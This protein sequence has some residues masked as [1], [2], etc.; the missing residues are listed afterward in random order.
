[1]FSPADDS[2][3]D[4]YLKHKQVKSLVDQQKN[5]LKINLPQEIVSWF[6]E[7]PTDEEWESMHLS[8]GRT[9]ASCLGNDIDYLKIADWVSDPKELLKEIAGLESQLPV[10]VR[11]GSYGNQK[12]KQLAHFM[13]TGETGTNL[14]KNP[15][16]I[17][18]INGIPLSKDQL[19]VFDKLIT[20]YAIEELPAK[21]KKILLKQFNT[22]KDAMIKLLNNMN[23]H[24]QIEYQS[25]QDLLTSKNKPQTVE[26]YQRTRM[27]LNYYKGYI[28][29]VRTDG[30]QLIVGDKKDMKMMQENGFMPIDTYG[31]SFDPH[32]QKVYY[33][34]DYNQHATFNEGLVRIVH[35]TY[36]GISQ[37]VATSLE[38]V[39]YRI[40]RPS[41][42]ESQQ[43]KARFDQL[44][45]NMYAYEQSGKVESKTHENL[46]PIYDINNKGELRIIA[47]EA[48]MNPD[49]INL[50]QNK[51]K[52][53]DMI[54]MW[55]SRQQEELLAKELNQSAADILVNI[56]NKASDKEKQTQF[57]DLNDFAHL[58]R[59]QQ[60]A[61]RLIPWDVWHDLEKAF[62]S[63]AS[64]GKIMIRRDMLIDAIGERSASVADIFTQASNIDP[65]IM[66][67]TKKYLLRLL[68]PKAFNI[69]MT[70]EQILQGAVALARNIIV[71]KS[72]RVMILN[73]IGN[74]WHLSACGVPFKTIFRELPRILSQ[75]EKYAQ[76]FKKLSELQARLDAS[77][78]SEERA[79]LESQIALKEAEIR[80]MDI[81]PIL[82]EFSTLEDLGRTE[83]DLK[84]TRGKMG[85]WIDE[86][87]KKY[88]PAKAMTPLKYIF[89]T[90]DTAIYQFLEK[91]T[92]YGDFVAK[93]IL[94][95]HLIEKENYTQDEALKRI[96]NEFVN[97]DKN[98]GRMR[99]YLENSGIMWFFNYKLRIL[100]VAFRLLREHPVR[101]LFLSMF[102]Q[103]TPVGDAGNVINDSL[104]GKLFGG[105]LGNA[106]GFNM[107]FRAF[108]MHP[109]SQ[110]FL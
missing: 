19:T 106:L 92:Q 100:P 12:A 17:C 37:D 58:T 14:I 49:K 46:V 65:D 38:G 22:N 11:P 59:T 56:Y 69:L 50:I 102:P 88:I 98:P 39:A 51:R 35:S 62:K 110:L 73:N 30:T 43:A 91:A 103:W 74:L 9:D 26:Q 84:L 64:K 25:K 104:L 83:D 52:L 101:A 4:F 3:A 5:M 78:D 97:Y 89:L 41:Q 29:T 71:V 105:G 8:L 68:G 95:K 109:V 10:E 31:G 85:E 53:S 108:G 42:N 23:T 33:Y 99:S 86:K 70:G 47:F 15:Y 75:A 77:R 6:K 45:S 87:I 76:S 93:G 67:K 57:V 81:Y 61:V 40:W 27:N 7:K 66:K 13:V 82:H 28:P 96:N 32:S 94:Y 2:L 54:G 16:A 80:D 107:L 1:M 44:V 34:A 79:K 24:R 90:K 20:L 48:R 55:A 21:D 18:V 72:V 36:N 60:D 63:T